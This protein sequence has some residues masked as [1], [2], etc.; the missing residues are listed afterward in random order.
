MPGT[1]ANRNRPVHER[2]SLPP[3]PPGYINPDNLE[4][5]PTRNWTATWSTLA[6]Q[7]QNA[8]NDNLVKFVLIGLALVVARHSLI[9]KHI[10]IITSSILPIPFILFAPLAGF[11]AD[12]F[13]KRSVM[14]VV[15]LA[16]TL[17]FTTIWIGLQLQDIRIALLGFVLLS[18]Q[19]TF[20][21]PAK[22]GIVKELVGSRR[23]GLVAGWMGMATMIAILGGMTVGGR[24]FSALYTGTGDAWVAASTIV[25]WTG[26]LSLI[27]LAMV[28]LVSKTPAHPE[29]RF[30]RSLLWQ[31]FG[32]LRHAL[33][34][35]PLRV[36]ML[37][38]AYFWFLSYLM[39]LFTVNL[40]TELF[41]ED[42]GKA[43]REASSMYLAIGL[44]L[45]GGSLGVSL[46]SRGGIALWLVPVGA[47][48][49][50]LSV[51]AIALLETGGPCFYGGL[52]VLGFFGGAFNVPL[53]ACL[54]DKAH[55]GQRGRVLSANN[56]LT[57]SSGLLAGGLVLGLKGLAIP[58][59]TQMLCTVPPGL[60]VTL[61][62][63][64]RPPDL[65]ERKNLR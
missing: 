43:A 59:T 36:C 37:G 31:H 26:A 13:S 48:G 56:L 21:S 1:P 63:W 19:S 11:L 44:G 24:S 46:L 32:H 16:Q 3:E 8:F 64:L 22:L 17:I 28:G 45:T 62:L 35:R 27:P 5:L 65:G 33:R 9:G 20:F 30:T 55:P 25:L 15:L 51:L 10:E 54:Q 53:A 52:V 60:L 49:M 39:G 61:A 23:L 42:G 2:S 6:I 41:P 40:G 18:I 34:E 4:R 12:R 58:T 29:L 47:G 57:A 50:T 38:L 7:S 14:L